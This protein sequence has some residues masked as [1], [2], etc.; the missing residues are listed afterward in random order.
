MSRSAVAFAVALV[1]TTAAQAQPRP[2]APRPPVIAQTAPFDPSARRAIVGEVASAMRDDYVEPQVGARA[3]A[4]IEQAQTAGA[5]DSLMTAAAFADRLNADLADVTHD[6][7]LRVDAPGAG[8]DATWRPPPPNDAGVVRADRLAGGVGYIE[9][10]GF[11]PP[12]AFKPALDRAMTALADTHALVVDMR[13]NDGGSPWGVAYLVSFFVASKPPVHVMD[14]LR[15]KP[16]TAD[17]RIDQTLTSPTP[18]AYLGKPVYVLTSLIT[19]S[20]GEEFCYDMQAMKLAVLVGETT[21]GGANPGGGRMLGA[22]FSVFMP[23]GRPVARSPAQTGRAS[24]SSR[25]SPR[26]PIK[27]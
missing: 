3:A 12:E 14:L 26:R 16:G 11:P 1:L 20:G 27:P 15:R 6:K 8:G 21:G 19:F 22:G 5:Y 13:R 17:Y 4:R 18:T 2:P 10:I 9:V 25:T 23:T 7:H 24:A